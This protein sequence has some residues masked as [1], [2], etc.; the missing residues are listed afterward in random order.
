MLLA[1][2]PVRPPMRRRR[3]VFRA[4]VDLPTFD[5]TLAEELPPFQE[6]PMLDQLTGVAAPIR[7]AA[8]L[9]REQMI[10]YVT[11]VAQENP[12]SIAKLLKLWMAE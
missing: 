8:D 6:H 12:D 2:V 4:P 10:E 7:S 3:P 11:T 9:T 1:T 5:S